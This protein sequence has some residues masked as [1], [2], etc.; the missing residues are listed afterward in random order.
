MH[1][2][3]PETVHG[4]GTRSVAFLIPGGGT[5]MTVSPSHVVRFGAA[6]VRER[7]MFAGF[8]SYHRS[9]LSPDERL[10]A[11][12]VQP[13]TY[14]VPGNSRMGALVLPSGAPRQL[15]G[16]DVQIAAIDSGA[17]ASPP[18][19]RV[20]TP[21]WGTS[22]GP[23]WSPDGRLLAFF[24][25]RIGLP[26]V[27]LWE[28]ETG[29]TRLACD[30]ACTLRFG[31]EGIRWLPDSRHLVA[32]LRAPGW[33]LVA[34]SA[35]FDQTNHGGTLQTATGARDVWVSPP[36]PG[37]SDGE[38]RGL[39][40]PD[41]SRGDIAVIDVETGHA[42]RIGAGVSPRL[43]AVSPDGRHVAAWCQRGD[44]AAH[45]DL[46]VSLAD[47]RVFPTDGT[48]STAGQVLAEG[49][50]QA[51]GTDLSWSPKG[52]ALAYVMLGEL[53]DEPGQVV[54]VGL[55]GVTR[56]TFGGG[57]VSLGHRDGFRP[58]YGYGTRTGGTGTV[59]AIDL[60][61]GSSRDL[62]AGS[63]LSVTELLTA[64]GEGT[65]RDLGLPG[66]VAVV[67][68]DPET[69]R[70]GVS[71]LGK[72]ESARVIPEQF[73]GLRGISYRGDCGQRWLVGPGSTDA[74]PP[75]ELH[76]Y[77]T[78][79]GTGNRMTS[80]HQHLA[81]LPRLE[82]SLIPMEGLDGQ[83]RRAAVWLPLDY[84][85]GQ[86]YPAV[87]NVY[88]GRRA[89]P[90]RF[91]PERL[92]LAAAGYLQIEPDMPHIP[93]LDAADAVTAYA[94]RALD[95]VAAAGLADPT[96]AAVMGHSAGGYD[97]CCAITRTDRFGAAIASAPFSDL[98]SFS[99]HLNGNALG[100]SGQVEGGH[101]RLGGTLWEER[102][103]YL[104]NSPVFQAD[105]ITTPLLLLCGTADFLIDQA[106]EMY[107][108]LLRL[109]K[110]ATLVRYHG[111]SHVPYT[112]WLDENFNDYWT[113]IIA[114]LD[115]HLK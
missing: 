112:A 25:D 108:A 113:R 88:L 84:T 29:S 94:L 62:A 26:Q 70:A 71:V 72:A 101:V 5:T 19:A 92:R 8:S 18:E 36:M 15:H 45:H 17:R 1:P 10:V 16:A 50:P 35:R 87:V 114:W 34:R 49:V 100:R 46:N 85:A 81:H 59:F 73:Q 80:L 13:R 93:D 6:D 3:R 78:R 4:H 42:R 61:T 109:G 63:G 95:A 47:V 31:Y 115:R 12:A 20:L 64:D 90:S 33:D 57:D 21:G 23:A 32:K 67:T 54:V 77:D 52:D 66:A 97:V 105:Q 110:P 9:V 28:R 102:E 111:E 11:F 103:R 51:Y 27:W 96:R 30:E 91:D 89:G 14:G 98:V 75:I 48:G 40:W 58:L 44:E 82:S 99:L 37:S 56:R 65:V 74:H 106:E 2:G 55:D 60:V 7:Q 83:P 22:W 38:D 107:A 39:W 86:R 104:A 69:R 53:P 68:V 41:L 43:L 76:A 24:S 79:A